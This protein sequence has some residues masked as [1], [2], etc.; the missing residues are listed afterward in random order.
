MEVT[1]SGK[2]VTESRSVG[3]FHAVDAGGNGMV[4][5]DH[6]GTESFKITI[7][8]KML[9]Y[10]EIQVSNGTL[11]VYPK[12]NV[13]MLNDHGYT[14]TL[15]VKTLDEL[16]LK[17]N[18]SAQVRGIDTP[19]WQARLHENNFAELA[20]TAT[21][22]NVKIEGNCFYNAQHLVSE[23]ATLRAEGNSS[24][25]LRVSDELDATVLGLSR[26]EYIGTP[27]VREDVQDMAK[28]EQ[29]AVH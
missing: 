28:L 22:Q 7:D 23:Q 29:R 14:V 5:I 13:Q 10:M 24:A 17:G 16:T 27:L 12:P 20:G 11:S 3:G 15:T 1:G 2:Y 19:L 18:T 26:V 25:V 21:R 8:E 9:P 4:I 6:T